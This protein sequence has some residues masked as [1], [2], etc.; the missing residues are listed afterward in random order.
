MSRSTLRLLFEFLCYRFL[1]MLHFDLKQPLWQRF[2]NPIMSITV[3]IA[4]HVH[5]CVYGL[6]IQTDQRYSP[7]RLTRGTVILRSH[8]LTHKFS[9]R[10]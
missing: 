10:D 5:R 8:N 7:S 1:V 2:S 6:S 3:Y 9:K 4:I